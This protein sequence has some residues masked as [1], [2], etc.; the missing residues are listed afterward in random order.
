VS[1]RRLWKSFAEHSRREFRKSYIEKHQKIEYAI[2]VK[3]KDDIR[4][5]KR[6]KK[7]DSGRPIKKNSCFG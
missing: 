1:F 6:K 2:I 3:E 7:E 5:L 4:N